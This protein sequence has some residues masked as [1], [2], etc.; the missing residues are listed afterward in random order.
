[1]GHIIIIYFIP[2]I[3]PFVEHNHLH[4]HNSDTWTLRAISAQRL[5]S[6]VMRQSKEYSRLRKAGCDQSQH[7]QNTEKVS[8]VLWACRSNGPGET[9]QVGIR[10]LRAWEK[11]QRKTKE[12]MAGW[13]KGGH[14]ITQH[15]DPG[16]YTDS[17][18]Q[19]RA[20]WRR[21][22]KELPLRASQAS[23]RQ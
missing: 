19:D 10:R 14:G 8:P 2:C 6:F 13:N 22:I 11:K 4:H 17:T 12:K 20:T 18:R 16:S 1:M 5:K 23:P 21:I 3:S 9:P 15:D 7:S